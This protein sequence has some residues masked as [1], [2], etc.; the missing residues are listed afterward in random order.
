MVDSAPLNI[1][2]PVGRQGPFRN[3]GLLIIT[4]ISALVV[5]FL[6]WSGSWIPNAPPHT[7][8]PIRGIDVSHHQREIVWRLI[9]GA[10][11][12]FAYIKA[13][14]GADFKDA[15]FSENWAGAG[16]AGLR[17]G[18]YH[19][20]TLGTG[21]AQQ[22]NNFIA[23]VPKDEMALPPAIDLEVSGYNRGR[24]QAVSDFQR[25]LT[26]FTKMVAKHYGKTPVIYTAKDFQRQFLRGYRVDRLWIREVV[27]WP[28][29]GWTLWQF[30]PRARLRGVS[31]AVDLNAFNGDVSEFEA[32]IDRKAD[33]SEDARPASPRRRQKK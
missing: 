25:E 15:K 1:P 4:S 20:F 3:I 8:Y 29:R 26:I 17:R 32:F 31:G 24:T 9:D 5:A 11:I 30:S 6:L 23:T 19:F 10:R 22:A 14:E 13:T 16:N 7:A 27:F 21:G 2:K 12:Q 18:A 33:V 28:S